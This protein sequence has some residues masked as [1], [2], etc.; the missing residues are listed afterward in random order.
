MLTG[1]VLARIATPTGPCL[2]VLAAVA[3]LGTCSCASSGTPELQP[4]GTAGLA[5]PATPARSAAPAAPA[6]SPVA[7]F[8]TPLQ[9]ALSWFAAVNAKDRAAAVAHFLPARANE[10]N[11]GGGDTATWS[12]F[13]GVRCQTTSQAAASAAVY[14]SF[15]ESASPSEGNPDSSWTVWLDRQPDGRW[16]IEDYGNG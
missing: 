15:A 12:T 9:A 1:T 13:T 8:A 7:S 14:C 11:W 10:M 6:A 4:P 5:S 2:A 16:L 3:V